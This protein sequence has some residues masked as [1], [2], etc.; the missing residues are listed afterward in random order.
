MATFKE[1]QAANLTAEEQE[2]CNILC[3]E[4]DTKLTA[5]GADC[6]GPAPTWQTVEAHRE[7][8]NNVNP[9]FAEF[10]ARYEL[11]K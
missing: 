5:S 8:Y 6:S 7:F 9:R 3:V 4:F 1:W 10:Y 11:S 2:Q